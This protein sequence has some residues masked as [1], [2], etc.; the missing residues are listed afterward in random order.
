[1]DQR[2]APL[3]PEAAEH[4]KA[5]RLLGGW[6]IERWI[7]GWTLSHNAEMR[8]QTGERVF[9]NL[10]TTVEDVAARKNMPVEK[11]LERYAGTDG[12]V[13]SRLLYIDM[14]EIFLKDND[15]YF[16]TAEAAFK[17]WQRMR[18]ERLAELETYT[19]P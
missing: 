10:M 13:D 16:P 12:R 2:K 1:M 9:R 18:D 8:S 15:C 11:L 14:E 7:D 5:Y 19:D 4:V 6:E 3:P 17:C